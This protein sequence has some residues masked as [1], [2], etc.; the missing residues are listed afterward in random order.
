MLEVFISKLTK[1]IEDRGYK[2]YLKV[3]DKEFDSLGIYASYK[4]ILLW[5]D[6]TGGEHEADFYDDGESWWST[7]TLNAKYRHFYEMD[8]NPLNENHEEIINKLLRVDK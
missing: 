5:N 7:S 6:E 2:C 3:R 8:F 1:A 4:Y